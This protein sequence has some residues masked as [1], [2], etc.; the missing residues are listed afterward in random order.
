MRAVGLALGLTMALLAWWIVP[1]QVSDAEGQAILDPSGRA[2]AAMGVLMAVWWVTGA[3]PIPATSLVPIVFL[4]LFVGS[5][6][7]VADAVRPYADPIVFLFLGG[8]L[9]AIAMQRWGLHRRIALRVVLLVGTRPS[10]LVAGVMAATAVVSM[11]VSN[12]ATAVMMLP[13]AMSLIDVARSRRDVNLSDTDRTP[14]A[15]GRGVSGVGER[16]FALC[17]LLGTAYAASVGGVGTLV[18][19][20][21]N[22]LLAGF[23]RETRGIELDFARWMAIG[24][25]FVVV[26]L[27]LVWLVLTRWIYPVRGVEIPGGRALIRRQLA[28]LGPMSRGE[29]TVFIVFIL[30]AT[31]WIMPPLLKT[32]GLWTP[33][34]GLSDTV[35]AVAAALVLFAIPVD[36]RVGRFALDWEAT[37]LLPWG[38]LLLFG[39][40]LSLA[41]AV[42]RSGLSAYFAGFA[43]GLQGWPVPLVLAAILA[44]L[45]FLGEFTSNTATIAIFLPILAALAETL[46]LDPLMLLIPATIAVSLGF[47]MPVGTPPNAMVFGTGRVTMGQMCR[48]GFVLNLLGIASIVA[49]TYVAIRPAFALE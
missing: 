7:T 47:M 25:P 26:F 15:A 38:T 42:D 43:A 21:P 36:R 40:G 18:G 4:P 29:W 17:L 35:V 41:S 12:T 23:L 22:A 46:H 39:G 10:A 6:F 9:L 20:P 13:I 27:P 8:F 30:A 19:T 16:H 24:V 32:A 33:L 3:L 28:D 1:R 34:A 5:H 11:W 31:A 2:V 49:L 44:L 14:S 37:T 45:V 48:A